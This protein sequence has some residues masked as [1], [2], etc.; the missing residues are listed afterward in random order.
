MQRLVPWRSCLAIESWV[1]LS[2]LLLVPTTNPA[3]EGVPEGS[4]SFLRHLK[5]SGA[6][7]HLVVSFSRVAAS[8]SGYDAT[9]RLYTRSNQFS[10]MSSKKNPSSISLKNGPVAILCTLPPSLLLFVNPTT[11]LNIKEKR[12]EAVFFYNQKILDKKFMF[13]HPSS[14]GVSS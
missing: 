13:D 4:P 8:S 11:L 14:S 9:S 3:N 5:C 2:E 6:S 1:S 7:V 12:K 10:E